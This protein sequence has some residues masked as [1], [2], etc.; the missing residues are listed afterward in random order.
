MEGRAATPVHCLAGGYCRLP[1]VTD[2]CQCLI[3]VRD[4][5]FY[6]LDAYGDTDQLLANSHFF[7]LIWRNHG[8]GS[9]DGNGGERVH[10]AEA[11]GQRKQPQGF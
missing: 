7:P 8:V 4:Q 3:E 2:D 1:R 5:V 6:V 9:Q 10:S 11:W